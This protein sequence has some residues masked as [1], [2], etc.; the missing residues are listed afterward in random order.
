M[1]EHWNIGFKKDISH[2][3]FVAKKQYWKISN[4]PYQADMY[5][6]MKGKKNWPT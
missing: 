5:Y 6:K 3:N 2:F 1:V 4:S